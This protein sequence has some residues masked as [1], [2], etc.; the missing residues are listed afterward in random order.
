M[1]IKKDIIRVFLVNFLSLVI[2][3]VNGFLIPKFLNIEDYTIFKTFTLYASYLGIYPLG[4]LDGM[5]I[6]YG[7]KKI[8]EIN[9]KILKFEHI[10]LNM[11][12]IVET[13]LM[14]FLSI[15]LKNKM[16]MLLSLSILPF[17]INGS[18]RLLFQSFGEFK[19]YSF[20]R[21][22]EMLYILMSNIF[23]IFVLKN[24]SG[25]VFS[26]NYVISYFLLYIILEILFIKK[27]GITGF[28]VD[29]SE[30]KYNFRVG[31]FILLGNLSN[32]LFYSLD[33]WFVKF[34]LAIENFAYYS[35]AISMM[36]IINLMISSIAMTFY[37]YLARG[38]TENLVREIKKYLLIIG[39]FASFGYF[40]LGF[41]V[42]VFLEKYIPSL[43]VISILFAGFPAIG[44]IN[45]LYINLYKVNKQERKYFWT[46]LFMVII[47]FV[48]NLIAVIVN[49]SNQ[50]IA[51]ATTIGFYVWF[52]WSSKDFKGLET[53]KK[54]IMFLSLYLP[55]F[56][57][58]TLYLDLV[59]GTIVFGIGV[60]V[61][62]FAFYKKEFVELAK[63]ILRK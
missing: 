28:T 30:I 25:Y 23:L 1:K 29:K 12:L 34:L 31:F 8:N 44:V 45:A 15:I 58:S 2:G 56:L 50:S 48:L 53:N 46:V 62:V 33:R 54:E 40:I 42:R 35:F 32:T 43:N 7:G 24:Y 47:S 49:K 17:C 51:L 22:F 19:L 41:I 37:P 3:I 59:K 11:F 6:K 9:I 16:L 36:G 60:S 20:I 55:L 13:F 21:Y 14:F 39:S 26:L 63:K 61:L 10:F 27:Y 38:Y 52:F 57:V 18:F 5:Y 4:F